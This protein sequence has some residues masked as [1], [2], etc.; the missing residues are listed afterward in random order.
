MGQESAS[1][2]RN[3]DSCNWK[4][5]PPLVKR[6]CHGSLAKSAHDPL[7]LVKTKTKANGRTVRREAGKMNKTEA[8]YAEHLEKK[9]LAGEILSYWF[10]PVKFR[11][12][13]NTYYSIDFMVMLVDG[14]IEFH[15]VKGTSKGK[16]YVEDDAAVKI[17]VAAEHMPFTFRMVWFAES[18]WKQKEI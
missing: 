17:K 8:R 10:E 11:L 2:T 13:D 16:P 18:E 6:A 4:G 15:E 7:G 5:C 14:T 3:C 12:A 9:K 1:T